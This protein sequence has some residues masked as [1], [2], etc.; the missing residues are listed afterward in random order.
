MNISNWQELP[1]DFK[2]DYDMNQLQEAWDLLHEGD[3]YSF[4]LSMEGDDE[5]LLQ[6]LAD[7]W[8]DFHNGEFESAAKKGLAL[9]EHGAVVL[10]K[11]V[12]AYC[13]YL[14]E[15][16]DEAITLLTD[17]M[18]FCESAVEALPDCAN[19]HFVNALLMGRYSQR[20]SIAKAL[21]Q[22]LGGKIK[23]HLD[24]AI[25][26]EPEHA[27]AHTASGLYHAEIIDKMGAMLGGMT[28]GA[29]K[30]KALDHFESSLELAPN[31]PITYI[32]YSNGIALLEGKKGDTKVSE[33]LTQATECEARDALQNCDISFA[34]DQFEE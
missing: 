13:D 15:D 16:E 5:N 17:A 22:G 20:I 32:E 11:S 24:T 9:K 26:L 7:A 28:Y 8:L 29:K 6:A 18:E 3:K 23:D 19:T 21:S 33:L 1:D 25:E 10:A 34:N 2:F 27:E 31:S 4:P 12:S 30:P 14:C